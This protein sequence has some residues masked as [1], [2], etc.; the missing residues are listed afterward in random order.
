MLA[1]KGFAKTERIWGAKKTQLEMELSHG[2]FPRPR[3]P[4]NDTDHAN[5]NP[6]ISGFKSLLASAMSTGPK[7]PEQVRH[8]EEE[9]RYHFFFGGGI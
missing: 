3:F 5:N 1:R 8:R 7:V 9:R 4:S 6:S 2:F